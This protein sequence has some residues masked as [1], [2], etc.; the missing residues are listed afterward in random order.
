M[1]DYKQ[2]YL[3][4]KKKYLDLKEQLGGNKTEK[5]I[6]YR[7]KSSNLVK[8]QLDNTT[9]YMRLTIEETIIHNHLKKNDVSYKILFSAIN[10]DGS[11][12]ESMKQYHDVEVKNIYYQN[13]YTFYNEI[14]VLFEDNN[15]NPLK[16]RPNE[17]SAISV[18]EEII[19]GTQNNSPNR[20][21]IGQAFNNINIDSS[22]PENFVS[23]RVTVID[24]INKV[25]I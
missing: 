9:F 7:F 4:Y 25:K 11:I 5:K 12:I 20:I 14:V 23:S 18:E 2:K 15:L 16:I 19:Y 6:Y 13:Q 22:L 8:T 3:K 10:S 24:D 21:L 17:G 1:S